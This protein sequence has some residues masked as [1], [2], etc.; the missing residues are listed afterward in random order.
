MTLLDLTPDDLLATTRAVRKQLDFDRPVPM[1]LIREC[2]E[3]ALQAPS[4]GNAQRWQWVVVTDADKRR[5]LAELYQRA[6]AAYRDMPGAAGNLFRDDPARAPQQRR[7]MDSAQFLAD[8]FHQVPVH[9]LGCV[10]RGGTSGPSAWGSLFPAAWRFMLAA[11]VRGLGTSWTTLHLMYEEEA[12]KVLGIP[13]DEYAQGV[14]ITV[15]YAR[16]TNFKPARR[17]PL[18]DVL[19]VNGW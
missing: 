10:P 12:A 4:G 3:L 8:H 13:F 15:G 9:V 6:F 11:R 1:A 17:Q 7:V 14:L 5:Q 19:H 16:K 2:L 18:D